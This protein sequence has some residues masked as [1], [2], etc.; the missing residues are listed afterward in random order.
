MFRRLLVQFIVMGSTMLGR[1]AIQA[2]RQALANA[3]KT[4]VAQET[5][6]N[7][8]KYG[9]KLSEKE[10]RMILGVTEKSSMD[11]IM[12]KYNTLF[13]KNHQNGSFYLQSKV[14]KAKE[15]LEEVHQGR[16]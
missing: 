9:S 10:A 1:A 11:E 3:A 8:V 15:V 2:Y 16:R 7:A 4:G 5:I 13:E 14:Q 12:Q 6:Q